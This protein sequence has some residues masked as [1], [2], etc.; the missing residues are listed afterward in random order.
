MD[1]LL[2]P[3]ML[4]RRKIAVILAPVIPIL[5]LLLYIVFAKDTTTSS[6]LM[7]QTDYYLDGTMY[8]AIGDLMSYDNLSTNL[9]LP[10]I[11]LGGIAERADI[12]DIGT[13]SPDFMLA[14]MVLTFGFLSYA[15]VARAVYLMNKEPNTKEAGM[16]AG[17]NI[18]TI[19]LSLVAALLMIFVASF[20]LGGFKLMLMLSFGIYFT[21]SIPYAAAGRPLGE[22]LFQGF[23][24]A[25][26]KLG[27]IVPAYIGSMGAAIMVPIALLMFT[28]PLLVN[29]ESTTVTTLVKL[30]VGLFS[31]V[32]AL[33]YQMAL[34]A[35]AVFNN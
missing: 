6:G 30:S 31:L 15:V 18:A 33:F 34:C 13:N 7:N 35:E 14:L 25:S 10:L 24:F 28:G 20:T 23:S 22:S 19:I 2:F 1:P 5:F 8:F 4:L 29:L 11:K 12:R 16:I 17:I 32:F 26:S 9:Q 27:K 21:F 3:F